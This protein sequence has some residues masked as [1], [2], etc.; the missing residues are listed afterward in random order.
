MG[1]RI[2]KLSS[3]NHFLHDSPTCYHFEAQNIIAEKAQKVQ[4]SQVF[5]IEP[6]KV[7]EVEKLHGEI[8]LISHVE[9]ESNG[10]VF[11]LESSELETS[12]RSS[13]SFKES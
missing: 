4:V 8:K 11:V 5:E 2:E 1:F 10:A 6:E 7:P 9:E 13:Q 12:T 3:S